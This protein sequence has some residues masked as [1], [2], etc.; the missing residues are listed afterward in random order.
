MKLIVACLAWVMVALPVAADTIRVGMSG[1]YFPFTFVQQDKLQGFE[2]DFM[3]AVAAETGDTVEF[4]TMAFSGLIGALAA[5]RIDTVANQITI[6]PDREA[7]FVFTQPYVYDGA[8][9]VVREGNDAIKGVE[10]LRGKTVA[11]NLGS[12]FEQL[13][14]ELPF[15]NEITIKTYDSNIEQDTALGRV[16][17][18][19]MDRVSSAQVIAQSPLPLQLAG[20]PFSEIRNALPFR[21]DEA[22]RALRDRVDAAITKLKQDGTLKAISEKWLRSDVTAPA[23]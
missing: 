6:T 14:R 1:G 15:A 7:K 19:V 22:G 3:N 18:F 10:D 2:V 9:V 13:L 4:S 11:V 8:Q 16:D 23:A 21:D 5:G 20:P 12:N 17:A